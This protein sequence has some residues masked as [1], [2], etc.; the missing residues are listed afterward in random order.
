MSEALENR[1]KELQNLGLSGSTE[2]I[3][4]RA[5]LDEQRATEIALCSGYPDEKMNVSIMYDQTKK[6]EL[7][8]A[9]KGLGYRIVSERRDQIMVI[10]SPCQ[11]MKHRATCGIVIIAW[12]TKLSLE[13]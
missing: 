2:G 7:L 13:G 1:L 12:S 10:G 4:I 11:I 6:E 3:Q 9:L 8:T 5:A